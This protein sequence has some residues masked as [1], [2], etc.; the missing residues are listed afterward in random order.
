MIWRYVPL[1]AV[2]LCASL[3]AAPPADREGSAADPVRYS[4]DVRRILSDRCFQCHGPDASKRA[5]DLRLDEFAA[6]TAP[7][8]GGAAIVPGDPGA[9]ELWRRIS[10]DDP[11][12]RMPPASANKAPITAA[13]REVLRRWIE[14]GA[15]YEA[16]WAFVP[17][18]RPEPPAVES[19]TWA[20]NPVD[21]FVL[22]RLEQAGTRPSPESDAET[23][24]RRVFLDLTGLPPT[25]AE[26]D[27]FLAD[28]GAAAYERWVD[29]LLCEEPYVSRLAERIAA[30]WLDA[31][32]YADTCGIHTDNGRQMWPWRDWVLHALRDGMPYDRFLT[33]QLAGDLLPDATQSQRVASG[34]NRNHVT[35]DEGGAIAEE[36]LVE[37]AVDRVS[38]TSAVFL[39]LTMGCARCHD[40]KYDPISQQD[41]FSLAAFFN[42]IDEPGLYSQTADSNRAYE[43]FLAV[44][45]A[46]HERVSQEL[47]ASL[48]A[49]EKRMNTPAQG[50]DATRAEFE[51]SILRQA[52]LQW[53]LPEVIAAAAGDPQV[54]LTPQADGSV[55]ASGPVPETEEHLLTLRTS[56]RG[57][58]LLLLE[59]L[60]T[61]GG[62]AG[63][64]R[65]FNGNGVLTGLT[66]ESRRAG[67]DAPWEPI[68]LRWA[69]TEH[70]Q[71]NGDFEPGNVLDVS[72]N[73]GWS[74]DGHQKPGSRLLLVLTEREFGGPEL[75]ELR[76][77]LSYR[78]E[79]VQH[80][81]GRVRIRVSPLA[82]SAVPLLPVW[83]GRW[84]T[85]GPFPAETEALYDTAFGPES[86]PTIDRT[87]NFGAGNQYW[88]FDERLADERVVAL[89]EGQNASYVGRTVWS[90]DERELE[91]SLGSDDGW[92]LFVNG[93]RVAER[94]IERFPAADQDTARVRLKPGPNALVLKIIN[95]GG[96]AAYYFRAQRTEN[97]LGSDTLAYL[98]PGEAL[99]PELVERRS[100]GWRRLHSPMFLAAETELSELR[101]QQAELDARTPR[102]MVMRELDTPRE[103]F[104][105]LRGQYDKPDRQRPAP[106]AVPAALGRLPDGAPANRL[107]L[108]QWMVDPANPLAPRVAVNRFW[109]LLFGAGLVRTSE[110]FGLQGE[111]PSH[112][113]LLDWLAVEFRESGWDWKRLLR[114]LVTSSTYRQSSTVR[115]DL[116][117]RDADNRW[118]SYYPRRR[119]SAEQIRDQAL[120][121]S[122][123]LNE[124]LGGPSVKPYQPDGLWPEVAMLQSNTRNYERGVAADL[125]RRSLYTYWK[126]ASPPPSLQTF[127]APTREACVIRRPSTNTPLQALVL[128]NDEQFVEAARVLAQRTLAETAS[129]AE[130]LERLLRRC[131]GRRPTPAE[132]DRLEQALRAFRESFAARP[133]EAQ[134]LLAVGAAPRPE[135]D[136]PAE[137]LAAWTMVASAVLNLHETMTQD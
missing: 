125:W 26:L 37:Y 56:E 118:L 16:H 4:R 128:W 69:W 74:L 38:T 110:D 95:T 45:S 46:E 77:R 39:G 79:Y 94:R 112:P 8:D 102:T 66:I 42:S 35:T 7:R 107:G 117:T 72:D 88:R 34:F 60:P 1:F 48:I 25:P 59:A 119:L 137:E 133:A 15:E 106:R 116:A 120:Y 57:L 14:Q 131:T 50:E 114:L 115:I 62:A 122:G 132:R 98:L 81:L 105:L 47:A 103:T 29:R 32:R 80:S 135:L 18:Q 12:E 75:T 104:V 30:P 49:V 113:E 33:E 127:D 97:A 61:P 24:L 54:T 129:D 3:P 76:V 52:A 124:R 90:P 71:K 21:A 136:A 83:A 5:A 82:E 92:Q 89:A 67:G 68:A 134:A 93:A 126:R 111:W 41:F 9:S 65:A 73:L 53:S 87:N 101:R 91:V 13:E 130:R 70:T 36:Y 51:R 6:A 123:L 64:G 20:R 84:Y 78:S 22:A 96:P 31:A 23:L 2:A 28:G 109:E 27:A 11:D 10:S 17:P 99:S 43:P 19:P 85:V 55:Q 44:P 40:H 58:R 108:A 63:A 86:L 121:A 100:A